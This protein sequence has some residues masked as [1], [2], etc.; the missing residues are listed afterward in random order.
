MAIGVFLSLWARLSE[1]LQDRAVEVVRIFDQ[2]T[3]AT[4]RQERESRTR[5]GGGDL[6]AQPDGRQ[7]I[8]GS[9]DDEGRGAN[10]I[11]PVE[12]GDSWSG[13]KTQL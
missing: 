4:A 1:P 13:F 3:V 11:E 2:D 12:G 6:F 9:G 5:D 7:D 10:P 8:L